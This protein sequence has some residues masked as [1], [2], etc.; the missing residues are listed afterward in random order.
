MITLG[1]RD[2]AASTQFYAK[3]GWRRSSASNDQVTFFHGQGMVLGLYGYQAL[4]ED[5]RHEPTPS[6]PEPGGFPGF[7]LSINFSDQ[8]Q[9]DTAFEKAVECGGVSV[10]KP[11]KVF[12]G[13]YSGYFADPDGYLWELAFNPFVAL[14]EQGAMQL[15]E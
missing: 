8:Q 5:A 9:V 1:V 3:L 13:G 6:V 12:W 10:K 11:E 4:A 2:V 15:P 14:D 7:S